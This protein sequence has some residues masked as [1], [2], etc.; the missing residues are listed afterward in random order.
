M[1][2]EKRKSGN[3]TKYYLVYSYRELGHV[4]KIRKYLGQ[5]LSKTDLENAKKEAR[6]QIKKRIVDIATDVFR[7]SLTKTQIKRLNKYNDK[8]GIVHLNKEEWDEFTKAFTYNTN[9]I[10]GSRV[11]PDEVRAILKQQT[12]R[13]PDEIETK[14]VAKAVQFIRNTKEELS[15]NLIKKIHMICFRGSKKFAGELR[16]V[17]V[18][19]FDSQGRL[20]HRGVDAEHIH[21][22]LLDLVSWYKTNKNKFRPLVLAA[23]IHNQFEYIHPFEDG[24]GRVGRLLLNFILIKNRY[25]PINI[26]LEDRAEYYN[27]LQEYQNRNNLLPTLKFLIKQ[28]KKTLKLVPTKRRKR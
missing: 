14:G 2:V 13:T 1:Y 10:E 11:S 17:D 12:A 9:A 24:N 4:K 3:S 26:S 16:R 6:Q 8:I 25:P 15:L 27:T 18:G 21:L 28:Y 22:A 19:V 23:I 20:V 7:F 5:N